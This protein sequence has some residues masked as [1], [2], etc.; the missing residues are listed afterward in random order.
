MNSA[1]P[2]VPTGAEAR[3]PLSVRLVY[4]EASETARGRFWEVITPALVIFVPLTVIDTY[5]EHLDAERQGDTSLLGAL[6][7][8]VS[9]AGA[10]GLLFGW[11]V[12][13]GLLDAEVG[14]RRRSRLQRRAGNSC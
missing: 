6:I 9:L 5:A 1:N 2:R 10:S 8:T 7:Q 4:R 13:A 14:S 12:F 11:V 3:A